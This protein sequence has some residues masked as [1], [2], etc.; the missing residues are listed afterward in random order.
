MKLTGKILLLLGI[1]WA[2]LLLGYIF[3]YDWVVKPTLSQ[4]ERDLAYKELERFHNALD[5]ELL[6]LDRT[7]ADYAWWDDTYEFVMNR[8]ENFIRANLL[9]QTYEGN[10][11]NMILIINNAGE[12]VFGEWYNFEKK[13][14]E[15]M[16]SEFSSPKMALTHP[17]LTFKDIKAGKYGLI[18]TN[19]GNIAVASNQIL[20]SK[21]EGEPRGTLI[22]GKLITEAFWENISKQ[23]ILKAKIYPYSE[24]EGLVSGA[25]VYKTSDGKNIL[26]REDKQGNLLVWDTIYDIYN[27]PI[28]LASIVHQQDILLSSEKMQYRGIV[29]FI[30]VIVFGII[31]LWIA[32]QKQ[33]ISPIQNLTQNIRNS[34]YRENI[35]SIPN[36]DSNDEIALLIVYFNRMA[37]KINKLLEEKSKWAEELALRE[38]Y[39]RFIINAVPCVILEIDCKGFVKMANLM[40][41]EITGLNPDD[42]VNKNILDILP[43]KSLSDFIKIISQDPD[44]LHHFETEE[45]IDTR[46]N[47]KKFLHIRFQKN[48][49]DEQ[50][51]FI[52]V[53][54]DITDLNEMQEKLN[55]QKQL[56]LLGEVS[57]SLAHEL[58]NMIGAIQSG[59]RLLQDETNVIQKKVITQELASSISRLEETL[60]NLLEFTKKYN[61]NKTHVSIRE[62]IEEQYRLCLLQDPIGDKVSFTIEGEAIIPLDVNLFSR[63]IWNI[64]KNSLESMPD[65]G[66]IYVK[67]YEQDYLQIIEI[68]DSGMGI[69]EEYMEKVETPF[70]TTKT[71]GTG[72]GLTMTKKIIESHGGKLQIKS[73]IGSGTCISIILPKE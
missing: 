30:L 24:R 70:F 68:K 1:F 42:V 19:Y 51:F 47:E 18:V 22:M 2:F 33:I 59:F 23:A 62:L 64:L 5:A 10:N 72:L 4:F 25:V 50:T 61:V 8:N 45:P 34:T 11:I 32:I 58:R 60:R 63:A 17:L 49:R 9:P 20:N 28:L 35:T 31:V 53:I 37:Y 41:T 54:W 69:E 48:V 6:F 3:I 67:I 36:I 65:G 40:I 52:G 43:L 13:Q 73:K 21:V 16:P 15:K 66:E 46:E 12:R 29:G 56:A 27:R 44:T 14:T 55:E 71:Q 57:A 38:K 7:C 26:L 39:F